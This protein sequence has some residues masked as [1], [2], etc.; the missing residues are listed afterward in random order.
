MELLKEEC[1]LSTG[2]E[3]HSWSFEQTNI[4]Q[5]FIVLSRAFSM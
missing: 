4:L 3:V 2:H 5:V 1:H